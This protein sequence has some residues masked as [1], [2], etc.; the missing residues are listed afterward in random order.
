VT[1]KIFDV[2][3][4]MSTCQILFEFLPTNQSC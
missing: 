3:S 2:L 4:Y 1:F